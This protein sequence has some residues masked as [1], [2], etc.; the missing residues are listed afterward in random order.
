MRGDRWLLKMF[1]YNE[2]G[3][4]MSWRR[5]FKIYETWLERSKVVRE[6]SGERQNEKWKEIFA[7]GDENVMR[8]KIN[9]ERF[10]HRQQTYAMSPMIMANSPEKIKLCM[11]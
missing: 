8:G 9:Y 1:E 7:M 6:K 10:K 11:N 5:R 4:T 2:M 3:N